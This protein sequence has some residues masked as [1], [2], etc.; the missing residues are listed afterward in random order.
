MD[1]KNKSIGTKCLHAS[2]LLLAFGSLAT[3]SIG[4]SIAMRLP[5]ILRRTPYDREKQ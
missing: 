3:A 1:K 4:M 2:I 5:S